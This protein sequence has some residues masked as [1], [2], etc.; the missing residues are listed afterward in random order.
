MLAKETLGTI[1][2]LKAFFTFYA[3]PTTSNLTKG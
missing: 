2:K 1:T 3:T